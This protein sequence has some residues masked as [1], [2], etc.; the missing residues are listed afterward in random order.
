MDYNFL[1]DLL[2]KYHTIV[3]FVQLIIILMPLGLAWL[4]VVVP[5]RLII[6]WRLERRQIP[7]NVVLA[8][9][10]H[11]NQLTV[12]MHK[13]IQPNPSILKEAMVKAANMPLIEGKRMW[14]PRATHWHVVNK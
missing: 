10:R 6:N 14:R 2:N 3:P 8:F 7:D 4:L 1:A 5:L 9:S 13:D 12:T 11:G